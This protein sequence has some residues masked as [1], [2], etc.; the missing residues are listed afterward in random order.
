[1]G[2]ELCQKRWELMSEEH[3]EALCSIEDRLQG[4]C[5]GKEWWLEEA[6]NAEVA[7]AELELS[8]Q[9]GVTQLSGLPL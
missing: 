6:R 7:L 8:T 5:K 1:V 2:S 3:K 4:K 9:R